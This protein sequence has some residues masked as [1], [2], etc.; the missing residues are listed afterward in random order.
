MTVAPDYPETAWLALRK[1]LAAM[2]DDAPI[3]KLREF[4]E[5]SGTLRRRAVTPK[6]PKVT[7]LKTPKGPK[8][9]ENL[10]DF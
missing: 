7:K 10:L 9:V 4:A 8:L 3:E 6:E 5:L 2:G 1:E